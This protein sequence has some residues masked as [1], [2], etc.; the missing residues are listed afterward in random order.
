M[1]STPMPK[2]FF[3]SISH[4]AAS[5]VHTMKAPIIPPFLTMNNILLFKQLMNTAIATPVIQLRMIEIKKLVRAEDE[6]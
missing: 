6:V 2:L 1:A 5:A 4:H 3:P